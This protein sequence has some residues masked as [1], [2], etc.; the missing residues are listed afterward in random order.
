MLGYSK[1]GYWELACRICMWIWNMLER[2][3]G[4]SRKGL[5]PESSSFRTANDVSVLDCL[6]ME[7]GLLESGRTPPLRS[8]SA[9]MATCVTL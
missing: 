2:C 6:L 9:Q 8:P 3:Y 7:E 4:T 1:R 5:E